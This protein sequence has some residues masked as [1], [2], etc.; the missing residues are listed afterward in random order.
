LGQPKTSWANTFSG[1][2]RK[3]QRKKPAL[4]QGGER[5]V[6]G[7]RSSYSYRKKKRRNYGGS[8]F[9][10]RGEGDTPKKKEQFPQKKATGG[11]NSRINWVLMTYPQKKPSTRKGK[12]KKGNSLTKKEKEKS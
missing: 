4:D 5:K 8:E 12:E 6:V 1:A 3:K 2:E 11:G 10:H 9:P 7:P